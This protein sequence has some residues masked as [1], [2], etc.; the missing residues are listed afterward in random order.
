MNRFTLLRW[1]TA[2]ALAGVLVLPANGASESPDPILRDR[3]RDAIEFT[4]HVV[5]INSCDYSLFVLT[6]FL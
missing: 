6:F 2:I 3:L 5:E 4:H 1:L